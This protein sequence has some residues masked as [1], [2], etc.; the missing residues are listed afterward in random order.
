MREFLLRSKG[1]GS[2][3]ASAEEKSSVWTDWDL[4]AERDFFFND[5]FISDSIFAFSFLSLEF[6]AFRFLMESSKLSFFLLRL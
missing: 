1:G 6:S 4:F 2:L 3:A 5:F